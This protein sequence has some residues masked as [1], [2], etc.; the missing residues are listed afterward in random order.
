MK[1][2]SAR[3]PEIYGEKKENDTIS[4]DD[5][6]RAML[7]EMSEQSKLRRAERARLANQHKLIERKA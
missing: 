2:L 1:W 3:R 7:E 6:L 4:V 5:W